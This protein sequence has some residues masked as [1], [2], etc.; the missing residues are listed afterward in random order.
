MGMLQRRIRLARKP[1][2]PHKVLPPSEEG[3]PTSTPAGHSCLPSVRWRTHPRLWVRCAREARLFRL[4]TTEG[5]A[6]RKMTA[7]DRSSPTS[8]VRK[9]MFSVCSKEKP[10]LMR[11]ATFRRTPLYSLKPSVSLLSDCRRVRL[12]SPL[13]SPPPSIARSS[14]AG[15]LRRRPLMRS[16]SPF[17]LP[18]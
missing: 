15:A 4:D 8:V 9:G 3:S 14:A 6:A 1:H 10:D 5:K 12:R 17:N 7:T 2:T 16:C 11:P 18:P 13:V